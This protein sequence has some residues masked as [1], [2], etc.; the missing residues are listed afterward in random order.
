MIKG[1]STPYG[2]E[3][4]NNMNT[5]VCYFSYKN[6][7]CLDWRLWWRVIAS[8]DVS[9][10][11]CYCSSHRGTGHSFSFYPIVHG[12]CE[13]RR[14]TRW[15]SW[16]WGCGYQS[17]GVS[18]RSR[19]WCCYSGW[20]MSSC[21]GCLGRGISYI[22]INRFI[23]TSICGPSLLISMASNVIDRWLWRWD[24]PSSPFVTRR[25]GGWFWIVYDNNF[26]RNPIPVELIPVNWWFSRPS[27]SWLWSLH[28]SRAHCCS[29]RLRN[30]MCIDTV[31]DWSR[32][33]WSGVRVAVREVGMR[34]QE[35]VA[36]RA[37]VR[38]RRRKNCRSRWSGHLHKLPATNA[39]GRSN[40][41][42]CFWFWRD[43]RKD[44]IIVVSLRTKVALIGRA[45]T[46]MSKMGR[47]F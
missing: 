5:Y 32:R 34:P 6:L 17:R 9:G 36:M 30:W 43:A 35:V 42:A 2:W 16:S 27:P 20:S 22:G 11:C 29:S 24:H 26:F 15:S 33:S 4:Y 7:F 47:I 1:I 38:I 46:K 28:S 14:S 45:A 3:M 37:V 18:P 12:V 25:R 39:L 21:E 8:I 44:V 13:S 10:C 40:V 41:W 31:G 19:G 23:G